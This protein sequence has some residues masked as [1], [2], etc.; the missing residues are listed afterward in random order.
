MKIVVLDGFAL[1]PGDL[2]WAGLEALGDVT[3]YDRTA[4]EQIVARSEGAEVL[5]TN[6]TPLREETI[7]QLPDLRYIGVLATGHDV[8]DSKAA[9][10]RKIPVC[11]VP[12]YGTTAVA[13]MAIALLL[14]LCHHVQDHST[15]VKNGAWA[16][17]P[18]FCFWNTPLIELAD[19]TI[20]LIGFG[21][22][23]RATAK[24]A[25]ALGMKVMAV[26]GYQEN[27]PDYEGFCWATIDEAFARADV[28]SFHC[29]LT[30]DNKG[31]IN[32]DNLAKMKPNAFIINTARGGLVVEEDLASALN[33]GVIAGA[34]VD[35]VST[36]PAK[37]DN[38][39]LACDN[40]LI[41]PHIAWAA[42]E[43]RAR[44]MGTAIDNVAA[45]I[46]GAPENV[47]N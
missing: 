20:A 32:K 29:P 45:Y 9:A 44:L 7:A 31:I 4:A 24:V 47:V 19:K 13:Q 42:K 36:E 11:N 8:V 1:N 26:D 37:P 43:S 3:V 35:V 27:A 14:E 25:D 17:S 46:N 22:I 41:T 10:A 40:C 21:R 5:L 12:T 18:D 28:M 15:A 34:A 2:D 39:L 23:G 6:K 30:D 38:P 33:D 16:E